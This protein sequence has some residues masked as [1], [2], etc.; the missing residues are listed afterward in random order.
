MQH[1]I[2]EL[3]AVGQRAWPPL[4]VQG[5]DGWLVRYTPGVPRRRS[6][7]V[8]TLTYEGDLAASIA[9]VEAFYAERGLDARFHLTPATEPTGLDDEL[10]RRGYTVESPTIV[11]TAPVVQGTRRSVA[12]LEQVND[13]WMATW[14][15]TKDRDTDL[16]RSRI[17]DRIEPTHRFALASDEGHPV[18]VG[19]GVCDEGW[20]GI[21]S[22]AVVDDARR[23]G[24]GTALVD[25]LLAWGRDASADHAYLQVE[26]HNAG[27]RTAFD[28]LGFREAYR[29][30]YRR[31]NTRA[32]VSS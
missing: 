7:S 29:Y 25:A 9:A 16:T 22:V 30:H 10:A 31:A 13:T 1:L 19:L 11:M 28:R 23:R 17:F 14:N 26:E 8:V 4:V 6:N 12:L 24:H 20:L 3:E 2:V 5:L 15:R 27:A 21:F 32:A 18:G